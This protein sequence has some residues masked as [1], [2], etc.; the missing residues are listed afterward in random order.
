[1]LLKYVR[2]CRAEFLSRILHTHEPVSQLAR[3][4]HIYETYENRTIKGVLE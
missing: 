1:M 3:G 4:S 2:Y